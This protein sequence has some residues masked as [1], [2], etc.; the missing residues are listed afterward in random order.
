MGDGEGRLY[1]LTE[2]S[3]TEGPQVATNQLLDFAFLL[4]QPTLAAPGI[5]ENGNFLRG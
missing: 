4:V 5:G 2:Q 1:F 3:E